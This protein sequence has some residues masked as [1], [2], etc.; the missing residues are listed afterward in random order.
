M[1]MPK[2][3]KAIR[4]ELDRLLA[5]GVTDKELEAAKSGYLQSQQVARTNDGAL[6]GM[7]D[8]NLYLGR[9]MAFQADLEESIRAVT[10]QQAQKAMRQYIDLKNLV[11]V[12]AGD[13]KTAE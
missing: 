7:L 10:A 11:V 13:L 12:A 8:S 9:T 4:E 5:D 1:N 3:I 2:L 6:A